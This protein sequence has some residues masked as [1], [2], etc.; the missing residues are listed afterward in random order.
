M[1]GCFGKLIVVQHEPQIMHTQQLAH[2][3]TQCGVAECPRHGAMQLALRHLD[4]DPEHIDVDPH[5]RRHRRQGDGTTSLRDRQATQ[6]KAAQDVD[7]QAAAQA[8]V[9]A[10]NLSALWQV[11]WANSVSTLISP[12]LAMTPAPNHVRYLSNG[13]DGL[14]FHRRTFIATRA[15]AGNRLRR[16]RCVEG[17]AYA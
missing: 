1:L 10:A 4:I 7:D 15:V 17:G 2:R 16:S 12:L 8:R 11:A 14:V 5:Q 6:Q 13:L 9:A 3:F